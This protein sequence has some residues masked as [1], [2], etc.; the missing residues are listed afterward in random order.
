MSTHN[1]CFCREIRK[2]QLLFG[3]KKHLIKSYGET[4]AP[5]T[6][7]SI[8]LIFFLFL[9]KS[10]LWNSLEVPHQGASN[11]Y[12]QR[13]LTCKNKKKIW[14]TPLI[15]SYE[16]LWKKKLELRPTLPSWSI[17]TGS[18]SIFSRSS[19]LVTNLLAISLIVAW[20][21]CSDLRLGLSLTN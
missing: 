12:P 15:W 17:P 21:F 1:I 2:Y 14:I 5:D 7:F 13:M 10:M 20:N 8:P 6:A 19:S 11:E 9:H 16:R 18:I 3:W 4:I